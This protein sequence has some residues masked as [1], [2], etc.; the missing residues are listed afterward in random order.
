MED[1]TDRPSYEPEL[2]E[3]PTPSVQQKY[4]AVQ[5]LWMM[6]TSPG[7]VFADIGVKPTWVIA[8]VVLVVLGVAAQAIIIQHVDTEATLRAR[9]EDRGQEL[10]EAQIE[11]AVE[12]GEKIAKFGPIIGLVIAP[13]AWVIMAA[14]FFVMLKLTS[15][16]ADYPRAL[17]TTL[18]GYWPPTIVYLVLTAILIQRVGRVPQEELANLVKASL[19]AFMSPDTPAW[20]SAAA[21]TI[22]IFNIWTVV[23]LII[24]FS[25]VG[26]ISRGKAAVV[27]LV[28]WVVWIVAKAG[29][30]TV[31]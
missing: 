29:L 16:E 26:K 8:M 25:A 3:P 24:G 11:N 20:L 18:H 7:E 14:I 19:G 2:A 12:Q 13:I 27:T 15:S 30:A 5:R 1:A 17:S 31:L 21:G 22:S 6:F 28:P 9:F 4:S 23:L 10:S